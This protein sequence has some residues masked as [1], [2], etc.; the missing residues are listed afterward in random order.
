MPSTAIAESAPHC[1]AL[2][3]AR[4]CASVRSCAPA[5]VAIPLGRVISP[6]LAT[7][8]TAM[9]RLPVHYLRH[10]DDLLVLTKTEGERRE[11]LQ[12]LETELSALG[13]NSTPT[14]PNN[15]TTRANP[16]PTNCLAVACSWAAPSPHQHTTLSRA[17]SLS[18]LPGG[19]KITN[20]RCNLYINACATCCGKHLLTA[21]YR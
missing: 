4:R 8:D 2:W 13:L 7:L 9:D 12:T 16:C 18:F 5:P 6:Y 20:L 10:A 19:V 17:R 21:S 11:A 1:P 15:A 14:K 3:H